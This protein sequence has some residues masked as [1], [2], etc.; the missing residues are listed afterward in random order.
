[1]AVSETK[2]CTFWQSLLR[3][4][5]TL[6]GLRC[7]KWNLSL[8][9]NLNVTSE[10]TSCVT[11]FKK[12]MTG[13][14]ISFSCNLLAFQWL[15]QL[16]LTGMSVINSVTT[17]WHLSYCAQLHNMEIGITCFCNVFYFPMY[18]FC[19]KVNKYM[20]PQWNICFEAVGF[21]SVYIIWISVP[22]KRLCVYATESTI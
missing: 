16:Q 20:L 15:I 11:S 6:T 18:W 7:Y 19:E 5:L 2:D 14:T 13:C 1:M 12:V 10:Y 4:S 17:Y 21:F 8:P 22:V 9:M 3:L